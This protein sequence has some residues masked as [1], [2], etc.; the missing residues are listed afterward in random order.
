M[1]RWLNN[2]PI[3]NFLKYLKKKNQYSKKTIEEIKKKIKIE[4]NTAFKF[5][6]KDKYPE[7]SSLKKNVYAK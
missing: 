4:I 6:K 1:K 2:D 3:A 5:A 7:V